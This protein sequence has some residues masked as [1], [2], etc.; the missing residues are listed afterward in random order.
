[1]TGTICYSTLKVET[2]GSSGT[3]ENFYTAPHPKGQYS[4]Y[5]LPCEPKIAFNLRSIPSKSVINFQK[6]CCGLL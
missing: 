2:S 6:C 5:S 4:L 1:M 3:L